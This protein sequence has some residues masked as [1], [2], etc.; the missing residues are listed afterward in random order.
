MKSNE[1][2]QVLSE[3]FKKQYSFEARPVNDPRPRCNRCGE[4][5]KKHKLE[6]GEYVFKCPHCGQV[7]P[8][9]D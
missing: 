5:L 3:A 9:A 2:Y 4:V 1:A 7:T 8:D 6:S